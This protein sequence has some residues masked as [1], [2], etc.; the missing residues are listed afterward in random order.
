VAH[1]WINGVPVVQSIDG[2]Y[3][4]HIIYLAF[5]STTNQLIKEQILVEGPLPTCN[6]IFD[7]TMQC[8]YL[9]KKTAPQAGKQK[10]FIFHNKVMK[11]DKSLSVL[12]DKWWQEVQVYKVVLTSTDFLCV[13][14]NSA[15]NPFGNFVADIYRK[16][17]KADISIVNDK[18]LRSQWVIGE[19]LVEDV[20]NMFPF[21]NNIVTFEM[22]GSEFKKALGL[23]QS[24]SKSFYHSSGVLQNVTVSP[25]NSLMDVTLYNGTRI[26]DD[27]SYVIATNDFLASGGD[28]FR[29]V[30]TWYTP[31]SYISYGLVRSN[32]ISSLN[33]YP[34]IVMA[35]LIDPKRRRLN[36]V[37]P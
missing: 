16:V 11:A 25:S 5:N 31:K 12:F 30:T 13:R 20:Y 8:N 36:I 17:S 21:E 26:A 15:E 37:N 32:F 10:E 1:H 23:V 34:G 22:T 3:Y 33:N 18:S 9:T 28:D 4:S 6:K 27:K 14:G 19:V 29:L 24:G 35:N 2:G 7:K